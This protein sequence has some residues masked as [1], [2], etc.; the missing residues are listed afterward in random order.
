[1]Q[2]LIIAH[3]NNNLKYDQ[4]AEVYEADAQ[5]RHTFMKDDIYGKVNE[6]TAMIKFTGTN[7][8]AMEAHMAENAPRFE[9]LGIKHE[10]FTVAPAQ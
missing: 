5:K 2:M 8:Q 9:E 1:M 4:W 10:V 6:L 7:P 3:L